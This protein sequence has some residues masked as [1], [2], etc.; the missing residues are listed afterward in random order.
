[1][2]VKVAGTEYPLDKLMVSEAEAI[3]KVTGEKMQDALSSGTATSM[4][5]LVWV[6]MKRQQPDLAFRD[7][8]FALEDVEVI[9]PE[10]PTTAPE[11]ASETGD[12]ATS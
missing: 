7:V 2:I 5:A 8:D 11:G 9:A 10:D 4:K 6:A 12:T 1:M 3:E